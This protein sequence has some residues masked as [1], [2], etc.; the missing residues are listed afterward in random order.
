MTR[1]HPHASTMPR[2]QTFS[3]RTILILA[4]GMLNGFASAAPFQVGPV[5]ISKLFS[6][7]QD[8]TSYAISPDNT[9]VVYIADAD[10]DN[11]YEL[12]VVPIAG[13]IST[14]LNG[15]IVVGGAV[16]SFKISADSTK[17]VFAADQ[18]TVNQLDLYSVD[19]TGSNLVKLSSLTSSSANVIAYD[20]TSDSTTVVY[21]TTDAGDE[22]RSVPIAGGSNT[23]LNSSLNGGTIF[24]F[25]ISP[26]DSTV[27]YTADPD[28]TTVQEVFSVPTSGAA[29]AIKISEPFTVDNPTTTSFEINADSSRVIY[30][31]KLNGTNHQLYSVGISGGSSSLVNGPLVSGGDI[32]SFQLSHDGQLVAYRGDELTDGMNELFLNTITPTTRVRLNSSLTQGGNVHF[33]EFSADD[34]YIVFTADHAIVSR[35]NVFSAALDNGNQLT[36]LGNGANTFKQIAAINMTTN[37]VLLMNSSNSNI[38]SLHFDGGAPVEIGHKNRVPVNPIKVAPNGDVVFNAKFPT[39]SEAIYTRLVNDNNSYLTSTP[40]TQNKVEIEGFSF[41]SDSEYLVYLASDL[42][43]NKFELF[44]VQN[45][46]RFDSSG[47]CIPILASNAKTTL[48]CL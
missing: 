13:G 22:L 14:K 37:S 12:Y 11:D 29:A 33:F 46:G 10:S 47:F 43:L 4:L 41:T 28:T 8:V 5:R 38:L 3:L 7:T 45:F 39:Q 40:D 27:I 21:S 20:I 31:A 23:T 30:H 24:Q 42:A 19:I 15:N 36:L 16:E 32:R 35:V 9:K 17:V 48:V 25:K 34:K 1:P 44:S 6:D 26:D 2:V 18:D